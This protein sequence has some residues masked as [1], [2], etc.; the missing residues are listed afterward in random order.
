MGC[1]SA[2]TV[3]GRPSIVVISSSGPT[4]LT[5][6]EQGLK[7]LPL[8]C[9]VQ[10]L[11]TLM[12]HPYLGPVMPRTSRRT[13]RS[14]TSSATS[15]VTDSPFTRKVCCAMGCSSVGVGEAVGGR[16][17]HRGDEGLRGERHGPVVD[18]EPGRDG[19]GGA[20]VGTRRGGDGGGD[21]GLTRAAGELGVRGPACRGCWRRPRAGVS[22][23][24]GGVPQPRGAPPAGPGSAWVKA[25]D[26]Q[27]PL[28]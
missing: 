5:C 19:A 25:A 13:Q 18:R 2:P 11:Q 1:R 7:A 26:L 27:Y 14:R 24:A 23:A 4:S 20:C 3:S 8:R 22:H 28:F 16:R 12:P 10:A 17:R 9:E 6:T 21:A 15:T